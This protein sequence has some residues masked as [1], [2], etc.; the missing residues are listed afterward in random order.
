MKKLLLAAAA[1]CVMVAP[2]MFG[3]S[4]FE[5]CTPFP[6]T[7]VGATGSNLLSCAALNEPGTI[8]SAELWSAADWQF[9]NND[10]TNTIT[11]VF[12][13]NQETATWSTVGGGAANTSTCTIT[14]TGSSNPQPCTPTGVETAIS[15]QFQTAGAVTAALWNTLGGTVT[16]VSTPTIGGA[17]TSSG[18]E[19]LEIDY[20]PATGT[21]EPGSM[22]LLGSGLLAAG[23]L[24]RKKFAARK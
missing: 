6:S 19:V 10:P 17:A 13:P 1:C 11:V 3:S 16:A 22:M 12:T 9:G 8:N 23:L 14:G 7:F 4:A 24:G 18:A 2:S 21:P 20:T 15:A 5:L